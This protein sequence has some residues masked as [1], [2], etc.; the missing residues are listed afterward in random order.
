MG[1]AQGQDPNRPS[2]GKRFKVKQE[3]RSKFKDLLYGKVLQIIVHGVEFISPQQFVEV[4]NSNN[5][6]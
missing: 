6:G 5:H 1:R 4:Y 3:G 2:N